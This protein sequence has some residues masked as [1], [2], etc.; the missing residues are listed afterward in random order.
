MQR[1]NAE[2]IGKRMLCLELSGKRKRGRP[3]TRFMDVVREDMRAAGVSD[4]DTASRRNWR[5]RIRCGDP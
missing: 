2:Y 1:R 5:L 4:R 3:K